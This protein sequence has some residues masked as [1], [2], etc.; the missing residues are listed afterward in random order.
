MLLI[1]LIVIIWQRALKIIITS[2]LM[3]SSMKIGNGQNVFIL[4]FFFM[5]LRLHATDP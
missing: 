3:A 5:F 2:I 4:T 1:I